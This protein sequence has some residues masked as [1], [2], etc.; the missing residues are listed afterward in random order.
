MYCHVFQRDITFVTSCL[1]ARRQSLSSTVAT[2][3]VCVQ[4]LVGCGVG[5]WGGRGKGVQIIS[6]EGNLP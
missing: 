5:G 2:L 3:R 6:L 1:L 4:M